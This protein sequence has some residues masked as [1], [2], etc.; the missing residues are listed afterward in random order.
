MHAVHPSLFQRVRPHCDETQLGYAGS[1]I[2][3][4]KRGPF[5]Q[6]FSSMRWRGVSFQR[7]EFRNRFITD[8]RLPNVSL[9]GNDNKTYRK[10]NDSRVPRS[11]GIVATVRAATLAPSTHP[12]FAPRLL[13][14]PPPL[15]PSFS[16]RALLH[17]AFQNGNINNLC[18]VWRA[19]YRK[20]Q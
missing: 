15:T 13:T 7:A 16:S 12:P 1:V 17:G 6:H 5:R 14:P 10:G 2:A 3:V 19:I 11:F 9:I 8:G 18:F 4:C 20:I